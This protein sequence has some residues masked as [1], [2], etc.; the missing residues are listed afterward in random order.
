MAARSEKLPSV[1][2]GT[3]RHCR[4]PYISR[5]R[6]R[7]A[8][9]WEWLAFLWCLLSRRA[10]AGRRV[11]T[12]WPA[13]V[14]HLRRGNGT[15]L[16]GFV[17]CFDAP[18]RP[19]CWLHLSDSPTRQTSPGSPE[20]RR[21]VGSYQRTDHRRRCTDPPDIPLYQKKRVKRWVSG[22]KYKGSAYSSPSRLCDP[23]SQ[24][25]RCR[26]RPY[27]CTNQFRIWT[28]ING[29]NGFLH[30]REENGQWV[31]IGQSGAQHVLPQ[32]CS[33]EK[34]TQS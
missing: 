13:A 32:F 33:S 23:D 4:P 27:R 30:G 31:S 18:D 9:Y 3:R 6:C 2:F 20:R 25:F 21:T 7:W 15:P 10:V 1:R 11:A 28:A 8:E 26:G 14:G 34:S 19:E 12:T 29:R 24:R 16:P 5:L 17:L 22:E